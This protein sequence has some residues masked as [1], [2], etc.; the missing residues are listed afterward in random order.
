MNID[1]KNSYCP[2]WKYFYILQNVSFA[3]HQYLVTEH[4]WKKT[5][6]LV[7]SAAQQTPPSSTTKKNKM[8][9]TKDKIK[10]KYNREKQIKTQ[11]TN[12]KF[13]Y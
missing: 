6:L 2:P 3:T 8:T 9:S 12:T 5:P 10:H 1:K 7:L 13:I 4:V 11:M